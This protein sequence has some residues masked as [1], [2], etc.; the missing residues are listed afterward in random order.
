MYTLIKQTSFSFV[1]LQ[2]PTALPLFANAGKAA[3][4]QS[5]RT[6]SEKRIDRTNSYKP[7]K[8]RQDVSS[9]SSDRFLQPL[10]N[11]H[12]SKRTRPSEREPEESISTK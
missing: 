2:H 11:L 4:H 6:A 8:S 10:V 5:N 3:S 7:D 9:S 12:H 1:D